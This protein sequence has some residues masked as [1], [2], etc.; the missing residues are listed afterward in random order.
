MCTAHQRPAHMLESGDVTHGGETQHSKQGSCEGTNFSRNCLSINGG[1]GNFMC[2]AP[3][4]LL[5]LSALFICFHSPQRIIKVP[6]LQAC[7]L[8]THSTILRL[9][10][11]CERTAYIIFYPW[12]IFHLIG[13]L[14]WRSLGH[15]YKITDAQLQFETSAYLYEHRNLC[16]SNC[17]QQRI[18][19]CI[20]LPMA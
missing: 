15:V 3:L 12:D 7:I 17:T 9:I 2:S 11:V 10:C 1:A 18:V 19:W 6:F 8:H 5:S 20:Y 16:L 13:Q 14:N 4:I